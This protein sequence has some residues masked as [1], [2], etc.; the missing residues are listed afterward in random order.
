MLWLVPWLP[1]TEIAYMYFWLPTL[2]RQIY[3]LLCLKIKLFP[4]TSRNGQ[5]SI[6]LYIWQSTV[7][8]YVMHNIHVHTHIHTPTHLHA[9]THARTCMLHIQCIHT[10]SYPSITLMHTCFSGG[11]PVWSF[12]AVPQVQC[13]KAREQI[14]L[15]LLDFQL[16]LCIF[17]RKYLKSWYTYWVMTFYPYNIV[18]TELVTPQNFDD[19]I[20]QSRVCCTR[21]L[22]LPTH[23]WMPY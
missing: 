18:S 19:V 8:V 6:I 5:T 16:K 21:A 22:T 1:F 15:F 7:W 3:S 2:D 12:L 10:C 23:V 17:A 20:K 14:F 13:F 4:L 11:N 9:Y